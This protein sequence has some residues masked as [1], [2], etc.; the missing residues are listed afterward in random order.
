MPDTETVERREVPLAEWA[1]A[2]A[3]A[4]DAAYTFFDWLTAV[5]E[6]DAA[7]NPGFDIVCHLMDVSTPTGLRRMMIRTRVPEGAAVP[8]EIGRAHV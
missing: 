1:S 4:R 6:T 2:V 8:S 5:D 7:E 3:Q